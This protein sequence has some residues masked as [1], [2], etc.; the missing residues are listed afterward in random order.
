MIQAFRPAL[1]VTLFLSCI[2]PTQAAGRLAAERTL[3][4]LTVSSVRGVL[5]AVNP[6][7]DWYSTIEKIRA[8]EDYRHC[9]RP[10]LEEVDYYWGAKREAACLQVSE[11]IE[12]LLKQR[13]AAPL[14]Q[15]DI[16]IRPP[17]DVDSWIGTETQVALDKMMQSTEYLELLRSLDVV[18]LQRHERQVSR[19]QGAVEKVRSS[20]RACLARL[21]ELRTERVQLGIEDPNP[22][23]PDKVTSFAPKLAYQVEIELRISRTILR[24]YTECA[25]FDRD[26]Q[27]NLWSP[28]F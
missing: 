22:V 14:D 9:I 16:R 7:S 24:D 6:L 27:F 20:Y 28:I 4:E 21:T 19:V 25:K 8:S 10:W 2:A 1:L 13:G 23:Q 11:Q 26:F 12:T 17:V 5:R 18:A 3:A 15:G